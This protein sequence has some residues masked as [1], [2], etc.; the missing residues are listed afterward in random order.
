MLFALFGIGVVTIAYFSGISV[1]GV[2]A[3]AAGIVMAAT[4]LTGLIGNRKW[5]RR[6]A[7][8]SF[9]FVLGCAATG[10]LSRFGGHNISMPHML[11]GVFLSALITLTYSVHMKKRNHGI[12]AFITVLAWHLMLFLRFFGN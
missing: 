11:A 12:M 2:I 4:F 5:H 7:E 9:G 10:F 1:H 8:L 6:S 3:L